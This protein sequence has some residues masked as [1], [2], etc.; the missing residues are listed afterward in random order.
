MAEETLRAE[1]FEITEDD[2]IFASQEETHLIDAKLHTE[3]PT[4]L[5]MINEVGE[6][7]Y[8]VWNSEEDDPQGELTS[9]GK[10]AEL[11]YDSVDSSGFRQ[12]T[13][14]LAFNL[15]S[16]ITNSRLDGGIFE[17]TNQ[18]VIGAGGGTDLVPMA[19]NTYSLD[20][21]T[22]TIELYDNYVEG[23]PSVSYP[24]SDPY[25]A[26]C[27]TG[28]S[29]AAPIW[30]SGTCV[31]LNDGRI[32]YVWVE[33][34]TLGGGGTVIWDVKQGFAP[35]IETFIS[36]DD[37]LEDVEVLWDDIRE[38][39]CSVW[40]NPTDGYLY[41]VLALRGQLGTLH[42]GGSATLPHTKVFQST[43]EAA[44]WTE[45]SS[46][47]LDGW[48]DAIAWSFGASHK[49]RTVGLPTFLES[50]RIVLPCILWRQD[51]FFGGDV[52]SPRPGIWTSDDNG[53]TWTNTASVY[54]GV[55]ASQT[56]PQGRHLPL[57]DDKLWWQVG[58]AGVVSGAG[59]K[60]QLWYSIDEGDTWIKLADNGFEATP[61]ENIP[62][63]GTAMFV[64]PGG[65]LCFTDKGRVYQWPSEGP[66]TAI[67]HTYAEVV[68]DYQDS[69]H[70]YTDFD[71]FPGGFVTTIG[72]Y[73]LFSF[74]NRI[75]SG[76]I[77]QDTN[78][79]SVSAYVI[80]MCSSIEYDPFEESATP[81]S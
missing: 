46:M 33:E 35:D 21:A 78:H 50:G 12:E 23:I 41:L 27:P 28:P 24:P 63:Y 80:D 72:S 32:L 31:E 17:D 26:I 3:D 42:F 19:L 61:P 4:I 60:A 20:D 44:T 38:P 16:N 48:V 75:I 66:N 54:Y 9:R 57:W 10:I 70:P 49:S 62:Y 25:A 65:E 53:L 1:V 34:G 18:I 36:Q 79:N 7:Y 58:S 43:D 29:I 64:E 39:E 52:Q 47:P 77:S 69:P 76:L 11:F 71:S 74:K 5:L 37:T 67:P 56:G 59:G 22:P 8:V 51:N 2:V 68:A 13:W 81:N 73:L 45:Y 6:S 55:A 40:R 30:D 15:P 14:D